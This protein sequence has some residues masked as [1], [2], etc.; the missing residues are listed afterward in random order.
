[1]PTLDL[2]APTIV[3]YWFGAYT[4]IPDIISLGTETNTKGCAYWSSVGIPQGSVIN[5]ATLTFSTNRTLSTRVV[6]VHLIDNAPVPAAGQNQHTTPLS[7]T[8]T[9]TSGTG[10]KTSDLAQG[11]QELVA[12]PGWASG[13]AM[14]V[15]WDSRTSSGVAQL[16][17][18]ALSVD[19]T[20]PAGPVGVYLGGSWKKAPVK[21]YNGTEWK[22]ARPK[23]YIGG[24]WVDTE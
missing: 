16:S 1:M 4:W 7:T 21:M 5:L 12:R 20:E 2:G 11:M 19:Y 18:V 17:N 8:S 23:V 3:G 14:V 13:N 10:V 22:G 6:G 15:R 9:F 24:Q